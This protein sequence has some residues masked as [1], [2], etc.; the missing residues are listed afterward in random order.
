LFP[1]FYVISK[2]ATEYIWCY[3]S[4]YHKEFCLRSRS[5]L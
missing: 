4:S 1:N 2:E 5:N 3:Y